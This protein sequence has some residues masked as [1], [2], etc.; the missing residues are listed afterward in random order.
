M[1]RLLNYAVSGYLAYW[2]DGEYAALVV[3]PEVDIHTYNQEQFGVPTRDIAKRLLYG[4]LYGCGAAKA[5]TIIDPNEK[6]PEKLKTMG[7]DAINS[8]LVGVP[9]LRKLKQQVEETTERGYLLG[10]RQEHF[11]VDLLSKV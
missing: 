9:A 3:N 5:G 2:D 1:Q 8:F 4:M 10:F 7:R 11:I 6:D